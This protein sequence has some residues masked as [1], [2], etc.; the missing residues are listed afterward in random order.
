M[1][2]ASLGCPELG[3]PSAIAYPKFSPAS[4]A[5]TV[6]VNQTLQR[7]RRSGDNPADVTLCERT[8][9]GGIERRPSCFGVGKTGVD[10]NV[11]NQRRFGRGAA[12]TVLTV[13]CLVISSVLAGCTG[14]DSQ[15]SAPSIGSS[16]ALSTSTPPPTASTPGSAP[17]S[18]TVATSGQTPSAASTPGSAPPSTTVATSGPTPSAGNITEVVPSSPGTTAPAVPLTS[19]ATLGGG[20]SAQVTK[21]DR[22]DVQAKVPE[23]VSGPALAVTIEVKNGA[24]EAIGLDTVQ[25]NLAYGDRPASPLSTAPTHPLSGTVQPGR[26]SSGVYAFLIPPDP[27]GDVSLTIWYSP[28][29]PTVLF[30]GSIK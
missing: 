23:E 17:L 30:K 24:E 2:S 7:G 21:V 6:R 27:S 10:Q 26:A 11:L 3:R 16:F 14:S 8:T 18:M 22:L 9:R 28:T 15:E 19:T 1:C 12:A 4:R 5:D 20:I 29:S 13:S 25:V